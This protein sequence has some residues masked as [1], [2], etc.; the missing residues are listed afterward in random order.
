MMN[1]D[2]PQSRQTRTL[3]N[4][5]TPGFFAFWRPG[6]CMFTS[7]GNSFGLLDWQ[8]LQGMGDG[9]PLDVAILN[10]RKA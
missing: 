10:W 5:R 3:G 2:E 1:E 6:K 8:N 9:P 7:A 4:I